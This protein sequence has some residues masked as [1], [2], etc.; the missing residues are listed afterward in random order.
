[1]SD[2]NLRTDIPKR[3]ELESIYLKDNVKTVL[4][5]DFHVYTSGNLR[6]VAANSSVNTLLSKGLTR[7]KR[8]IVIPFL[9]AEA[10]T[11]SPPY[12]H[13]DDFNVHL[14]NVNIYSQNIDFN[15]Q[16][17]IKYNFENFLNEIQ[18]D[19]NLG[20]GLNDQMSSG[21][22]NQQVFN[23]YPS[24]IVNLERKNKF[25]DIVPQSIGLTFKNASSFKVDYTVII[26]YQRKVHLDRSTGMIII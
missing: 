10:S 14:N 15:V 9:N 6:N 24:L 20:A 3:L 4:F 18:L 17:N 21:L 26:E 19:S 12:F 1:M 16:L 11:L 25:K 13:I 2:N 23:K 8:L 7:I 22:I 5:N